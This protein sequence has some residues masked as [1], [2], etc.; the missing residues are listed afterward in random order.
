MLPDHDCLEE[1]MSADMGPLAGLTKEF[2][3]FS[4]YP[5]PANIDGHPLT[6]DLITAGSTYT[7]IK[8]YE[9]LSRSAA[10]LARVGA[11]GLY[12]F[13]EYAALPLTVGATVQNLR[14]ADRCICREKANPGA[15]E[16]KREYRRWLDRQ[17]PAYSGPAT[18]LGF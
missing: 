9:A 15:Y 10:P 1:E 12:L 3:V 13:G 8:A 2:S 4:M 5:N 17:A 11:Q 18:P 6:T 7:K 14:V 16:R